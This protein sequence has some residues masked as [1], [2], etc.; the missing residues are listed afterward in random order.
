MVNDWVFFVG[1]VELTG[2]CL[3]DLYVLKLQISQLRT[4]SSMQ[5]LKWMLISSVVFLI[6]AALPLMFVY[7]N[8]LWFHYTN[9]WII[10]IAILTN[11]TAKLIIG[12]VLVA[13]YRFK[14]NGDKMNTG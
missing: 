6:F 10:Y 2:A 9:L 3:I 4:K 12:G 7:A 14:D 5:P 1:L 13:I 11:S 8:T